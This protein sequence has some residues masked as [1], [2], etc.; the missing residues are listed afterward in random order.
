MAKLL[1]IRKQKWIEKRKPDYIQGDPLNANSSV[2]L[3]YYSDL[4]R[5]IDLMTSS[6]EKQI[7]DLFKS[8]VSEEFYAMDD[9]LSSQARILTNIL[10]KKFNKKF[11]VGSKPIAER[12]A[13]GADGASSKQLHS[14]LM[15]LTGGLSLSTANLDGPML[16]IYKSVINENVGLIKS[17]STRY[18]T[19]VQN[20]VFRSITQGNGLA[21]LV[22]FLA[23]QKG[24][25]LRH[26]NL[27]ALDQNRKAS[28]GFNKARM[29][30]LGL[31][32]F[33]W[34]H[35][36]GSNHP[37]KHH[38]DLS[39]G[40]FEFDNPPVIDEKTGER[41]FPGQLINCRCQMIP[42]IEFKEK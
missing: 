20:A 28:N 14:S 2:A 15:K 6:V 42:V 13:R 4:A 16:D 31:T 35:S 34:K 17:I 1:T 22:P 7:Q 8:E 36:G 38:Q 40:I 41:G 27:I 23:K 24:I 10:F 18:L 33:K 3:R 12:F 11:A 30:N 32:K 29:E 19:Q 5:L 26:A 25:T 21:D 9:S 39:G 37:R